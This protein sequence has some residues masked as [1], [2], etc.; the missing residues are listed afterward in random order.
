MRGVLLILLSLRGVGSTS[1]VEVEMDIFQLVKLRDGLVWRNT[2]F[3]NRAE[4]I[5]AARAPDKSVACA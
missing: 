1:G 5:E 4:A 2:F 3:R